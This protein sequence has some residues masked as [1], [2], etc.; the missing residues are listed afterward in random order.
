MKTLNLLFLAIV[1]TICLNSCSESPE[2]YN[3]RALNLADSVISYSRLSFSLSSDCQS[4][5]RSVIFDKQYISPV[6]NSLSY[7]S[8]FN[9]GISR[10]KDDIKP[11]KTLMLKDKN[12]VDSIY[13]TLKDTPEKSDKIFEN[14]KELVSVYD[15]S[16]DMAFEPNGSLNDYTS[17]LNEL[18]SKFKEL[19]SKIELDKK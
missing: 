6:L 11:F 5:W 16:I 1:F 19:K 8:D 12:Y 15:R 2:K 9:D 17:N 18:L 4:M 10:Y 14:V 3:A 13:K 7:C